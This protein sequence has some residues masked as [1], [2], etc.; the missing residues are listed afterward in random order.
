MRIL[1]MQMMKRAPLM[2]KVTRKRIP[3]K[4][5]TRRQEEPPA[6]ITLRK[7]VKN[8]DTEGKS[9]SAG[10]RRRSIR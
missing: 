8:R 9:V 5:A 7:T 6:V 4:R 3:K 2:R 10:S 1:L